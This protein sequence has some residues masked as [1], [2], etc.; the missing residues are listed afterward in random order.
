MKAEASEE[1][2][3][4]SPFGIFDSPATS[5]D[6]A[7]AGEYLDVSSSVE[8]RRRKLTKRLT[9]MTTQMENLSNQIYHL[10]QRLELIEQKLAINRSE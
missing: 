6:S 2:S 4:A 3:Q 9:D 1:T 5:T 10:Q 7:E 8:E